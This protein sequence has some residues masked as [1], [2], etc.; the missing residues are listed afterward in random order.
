MFIR[1]SP[2]WLALCCVSACGG[3]SRPAAEPS[4]SKAESAGDDDKPAP[5]SASGAARADAPAAPDAGSGV[6]NNPP[7]AQLPP[8][9][10][11]D[12]TLVRAAVDAT[13]A[14]PDERAR[15]GL[16]LAVVDQGPDTPW[17]L[18]L[19]NRG[20]EPLR[21]VPDLRT[22]SL[23]VTAPMPEPDPK[24]KGRPPRAPKPVTCTLP[25]GLVPTEED[26][27]LET[28]LEPGEGIVDSFDPRLYCLPVAGKSPL[29]PGANVVARLGWPEKTKTVWRKGKKTLR[30]VEQVAPFVARKAVVAGSLP[31]A[32]PPKASN[33]K[34]DAQSEPQSDARAIK[35]AV[36]SP[37]TL[38][39]AYV[40]EKP[41]P[42]EGLELLLTRGSDAS[43]ERD[44]TISVSLVNR[45]KK[46][47]RVYFRREAVTFEVSGPDGLVACDPGPD[48]RAP[49]RS[50]FSTLRPGGRLSATSRLIEMCPQGAMRRPGLYLVHAR[51]DGLANPDAQ[52]PVTFSGRVVSR[53]PVTIRV[54]RGWG[55]LPAQRAPERVRV[56]TP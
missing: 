1:L 32:P 15:L 36:A 2:I 18:A 41:E 24:K 30:V 39:A 4:S 8:P 19:V 26:S 10:L 16:R 11:H 52:G 25:R 21:V 13:A 28:Q 34:D 22:L 17:L 48:K 53:E 5:P 56:G 55:D 43:T 49:D 23:E 45:G 38:G 20:T 42:V 50:G 47:E 29:V 33:E 14:A 9:P 3:A 44:A 31:E 35:Q 46:M 27:S 54:R 12:P 40:R 6:A 51:Y 37:L 7:A